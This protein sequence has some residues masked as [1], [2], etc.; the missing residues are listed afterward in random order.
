LHARLQTGK[1]TPDGH[2]GPRAP[3]VEDVSVLPDQTILIV[4]DERAIRRLA[5]NILRRAGYVA[6]SKESAAAALEWWA[7]NQTRV[8]LVI[9]DA[10]MPG[11][12]GPE[13]LLRMRLDRPDLRAIVMS[14]YV[15][16]HGNRTEIHSSDA[17]LQKPFT[18]DQLRRAVI[19]KLR[20]A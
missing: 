10:V 7:A 8:T 18:P 9:T 13:M 1:V 11:G 14:G 20:L 16:H 12:S 15:E 6:I 2:D 3:N 19:D 4:D 17:F 5:E